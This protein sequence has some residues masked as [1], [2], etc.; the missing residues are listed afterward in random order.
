LA[1]VQ[2]LASLRLEAIRSLELSC[3]I[4]RPL[5]GTYSMDM[6]HA[7]TLLNLGNLLTKEVGRSDSRRVPAPRVCSPAPVQ[8]SGGKSG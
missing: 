7:D 3:D 5:A 6:D 1:K 8:R 4:K 2:A